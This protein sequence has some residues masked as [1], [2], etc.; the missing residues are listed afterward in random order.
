MVGV[1]IH[2]LCPA[3]V[4]TLNNA[5]QWRAAQDARHETETQSAR[6]LKQQCSASYSWSLLSNAVAGIYS[7]I[8]PIVLSQVSTN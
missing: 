1:D 5:G 3:T 8:I 2:K 6:P 4:E 7:E